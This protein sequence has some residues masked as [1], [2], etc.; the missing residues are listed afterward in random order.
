MFFG[1]S[2]HL[3]NLTCGQLKKKKKKDN[4]GWEQVGKTFQSVGWFCLVVGGR[5][6]GARGAAGGDENGH[7]ATP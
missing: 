3:C 7:D 4:L 5:L 6:M 1:Y 2:V